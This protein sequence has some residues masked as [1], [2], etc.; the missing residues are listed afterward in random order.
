MLAA[1]LLDKPYARGC[2]LAALPF[3][4]PAHRTIAGYVLKER[5][6]GSVR[7]SGIF[8]LLPADGELAEIFDL[9]YGDNLDSPAAEKYFA[10]CVAALLRRPL[11]EKIAAARRDYENA[12]TAEE[13]RAALVRINEY[14]KELKNLSA[15]G[16][17]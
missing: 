1:A 3:D 9:D 12:S 16:K 7:A 6:S 11:S 8:D 4:D 14:T 2:D 5:R 15:G 10:D 17:V 13:R